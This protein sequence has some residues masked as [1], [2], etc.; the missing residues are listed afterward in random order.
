MI[1]P[2]EMIRSIVEQVVHASDLVVLKEAE[3]LLYSS[4]TS[5]DGTTS[6]KFLSSIRKCPRPGG[7][8]NLIPKCLR[9]MV[10]LKE[11]G[12]NNYLLYETAELLPA[13]CPFRLEKF[14]WTRRRLIPSLYDEQAIAFLEG[15][16]QLS[17][18]RWMTTDL[19]CP[20]KTLCPNLRILEG[21]TQTFLT[22]LPGRSVTTLYWVFDSTFEENLLLM[23]RDWRDALK[24]ISPQLKMIQVTLGHL[25]SLEALE[26]FS[27]SDVDKPLHGYMPPKLKT[28][29]ISPGK[30]ERERT[31]VDFVDENVKTASLVHPALKRVY[32]ALND[33]EDDEITYKAWINTVAQPELV[34]AS[35]ARSDF[36]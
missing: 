3:R 10:N 36:A 5:E 32:L 21:N 9:A 26:V 24:A 12:F 31:G 18:L 15:Q 28:L 13:T 33:P 20:L 19:I 23:S 7:I 16:P 17:H 29:I 35:E 27:L 25:E 2:P 34:D 30:W 6:F 22:F 1:L 14:I 11:L 8:L 4:M